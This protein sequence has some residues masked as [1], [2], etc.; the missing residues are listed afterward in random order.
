MN[1]RTNFTLALAIVLASII[2]V[3]FSV[4]SAYAEDVVLQKKIDQVYVKNDKNGDEYVTFRFKEER[5]LNGIS[6]NISV[7]ATCF[8]SSGMLD[9]AKALSKG[10]E[11]KV[12]AQKGEYRGNDSYVIMAFIE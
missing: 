6:Y 10:D 12:I 4:S 8:A 2:A 9:Q 7:P 11:L 3:T 1:T 5:K